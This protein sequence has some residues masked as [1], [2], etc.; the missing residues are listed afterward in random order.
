DEN[1]IKI[2]SG[3]LAAMKKCGDDILYKNQAYNQLKDMDKQNFT[4]VWENLKAK[5]PSPYRIQDI[6]DLIL[7]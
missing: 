7:F 5:L 4:R 1:F 3:I 2:K 6:Y